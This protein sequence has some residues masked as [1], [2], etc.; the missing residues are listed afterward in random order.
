MN[1]KNCAFL[2]PG[3]GSQAVG[4][5]KDLF[6]NSELGRR[7]FE[8]ADDVL[9][10][11]LSRICFEGPE[12]ELK[13]THNTQPALL[14]VSAI[15]F[16]M[17]GHE[18]AVAAG[19]SLG[20]YS[21]FLCADVLDFSHAVRLVHNRGKYMQEA[22][23]VGLG[24]MAALIGADMDVL[25]AAI[26]EEEGVVALANH[27][28]AAQMV[29]S[30]EKAAVESVVSRVKAPRHVFLPVSAPFHSPLMLPAEE[31]LA[32][33]LAEISFRDPRFPIINNV[34]ADAVTLGSTARDGLRRQVSRP[35]LWYDT[36]IHLLKEMGVESFV[37]VGTGKVLSGLIRRTARD[38]GLRVEVFQ[39][40]SLD[41]LKALE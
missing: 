37:E 9:G 35:V 10:Y 14:T 18:P 39:L 41:D 36:M 20:E 28:S 17:L 33:D 40:G 7:M 23:P 25:K 11:S 30:G 5:G 4:M 38:L 3:Q 19:H 21:A 6:E 27:N 8:E 24:A 32:L 31:K 1:F 16:R 22:V 15:L 13:L 12:E 2:F 26:A 34:D 29:I